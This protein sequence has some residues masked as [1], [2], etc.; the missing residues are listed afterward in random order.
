MCRLNPPDA[1][2][3]ANPTP[4]NDAVLLA[5]CH[6]LISGCEAL[7]AEVGIK[8]NTAAVMQAAWDAANAAQAEVGQVKN[9][10]RA[11]AQGAAGP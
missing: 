4:T 7:E 5:R 8:Q 3:A 6:D 9:G 2:I 10:A 1:A 11:T